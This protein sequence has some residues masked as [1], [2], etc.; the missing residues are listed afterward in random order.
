MIITKGNF[1][2]CRCIEEARQLFICNV[3]YEFKNETD[4]KEIEGKDI[5]YTEQLD[6]GLIAIHFKDG[7][8]EEIAYF[9][10]YCKEYF[11]IFYKPFYKKM[12]FKIFL[13][14]LKKKINNNN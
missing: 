3:E 10:L 12:M 5:N 9:Y 8:K 7:Q 6:N 2:L 11:K 4:K 13:F 1:K 14:N